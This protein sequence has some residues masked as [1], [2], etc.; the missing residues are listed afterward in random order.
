MDQGKS[1]QYWEN[2]TTTWEKIATRPL[3]NKY[4]TETQNT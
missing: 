2:R 3:F 1:L 4:K